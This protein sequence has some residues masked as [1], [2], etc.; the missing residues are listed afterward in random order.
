MYLSLAQAV[1]LIHDHSFSANPRVLP[2]QHFDLILG[3]DWLESFSPMKVHWK[4]KWM[5]IPYEYA[6][7]TLQGLL[8]QILAYS[9]VQL[10]SISVHDQL[11]ELSTSLDPKVSA[12][13]TE[14]AVVFAPVEGL[15]PSRTC[16]HTI[17]L[18]AGAK[19]VYLPPY[20]YPPTLKNEIEKQVQDMLGKGLIQHSNSP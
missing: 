16:D 12:L 11:D 20:R 10:C 13:L 14:F 19:L 7:M 1:W 6:S 18:L 17:P 2:L 5:S 8:A 15:P 9:V 4:F 3:M